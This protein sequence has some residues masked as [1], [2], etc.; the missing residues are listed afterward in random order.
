[1][2]KPGL[3]SITFRQLGP[4]AIVRLVAEAGLSGIE[5]GGDIHVPHGDT[6]RACEVRK[7]T[8]DAGLVVAAY[9]S[10]YRAGARTTVPFTA[11]LDS[12][13]ALGAPL[14]RVWAGEQGSAQADAAA[15]AAVTEAVRDACAR[16]AVH[17]IRIGLEFH[18]NTLTDTTDSAL[19]LLADADHPNLLCYWQPPVGWPQAQLE[20]SLARILPHLA[21]LH[22]FNWDDQHQRRPLREGFE[23][24]RPLLRTAHDRRPGLDAH[25]MI[26]FVCDDSPD[27]FREDAKALRELLAA[28]SDPQA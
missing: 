15:R 21:H 14:I 12:A 9:G 1:M 13:L 26:E 23:K 2:L 19:Q 8:T 27:A 7:L 6:A 11:I 25:A 24:W 22:V 28:V 18:G 10:Y 16:A 4:E 17:H 20:E 3:V 5:W